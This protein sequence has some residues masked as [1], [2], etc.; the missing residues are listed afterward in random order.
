[1]LF[2]LGCLVWS[3]CERMP[4][5]LQ[6]LNVPVLGDTKGVFHPLTGEGDRGM[7]DGEGTVGR[8]DKREGSHWDVK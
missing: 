3:Q 8:G 4:L 5:A 1:M 2:L 6:R 7:E